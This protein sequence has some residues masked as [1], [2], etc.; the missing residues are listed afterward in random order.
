[1][2]GDRWGNMDPG[3][4]TATRNAASQRYTN[5]SRPINK[6]TYLPYPSELRSCVKVEVAVLGSPSLLVLNMVCADVSAVREKKL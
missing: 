5:N 6:L 4:P 3:P 2:H 1:M